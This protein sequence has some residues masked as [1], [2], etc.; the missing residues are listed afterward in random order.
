MPIAV[1]DYEFTET[2]QFIH[3]TVSFPTISPSK[4]DIYCNDN[5]LKIN[6]S[7]Y[8]FELDLLHDI[9]SESSET[10]ASVGDNCVKFCLKKV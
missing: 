5:Y 9:D 2:E 1:K 7:P 3:I 8:I 10:L 4:A 6:S